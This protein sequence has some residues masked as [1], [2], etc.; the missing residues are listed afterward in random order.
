MLLSSLLRRCSLACCLFLLVAQGD[1]LRQAR[2]GGEV[3]AHMGGRCRVESA[4]SSAV[5]G[6]RCCSVR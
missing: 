4:W 3:H 5:F 2:A 1:S 6:Q